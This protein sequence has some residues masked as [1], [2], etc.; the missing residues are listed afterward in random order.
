MGL[1]TD[2]Y[3]YSLHTSL[4]GEWNKSWLI[5]NNK[6]VEV[7]DKNEAVNFCWTNIAVILT[8]CVLVRFPFARVMISIWMLMVGCQR[9][10]SIILFCFLFISFLFFSFFHESVGVSKIVD[11]SNS[12]MCSH[13]F[14]F[15]LVL[16]FGFHFC[17]RKFTSTLRKCKY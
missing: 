2:T 15:H 13:R 8:Y 17:Y 12:K 11:I 6:I 4:K 16:T 14:V 5:G 3:V 10:A 7:Q 9:C 1:G